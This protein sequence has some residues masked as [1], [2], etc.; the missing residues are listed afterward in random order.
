[1]LLQNGQSLSAVFCFKQIILLPKGILQNFPVQSGI[2]DDQKL[3]SGFTE[4]S[5]ENIF[6]VYILKAHYTV[7][8]FSQFPHVGKFDPVINLVTVFVYSKVLGKG[9]TDLKLLLQIRYTANLFHHVFVMQYNSLF[10]KP[11]HNIRITCQRMHQM[12]VG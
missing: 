1:M 7:F 2:I 9:F 8:G 10:D 5:V 12:S 11:V 3:L 4:L 6:Q